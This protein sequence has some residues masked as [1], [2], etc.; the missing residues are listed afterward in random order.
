MLLYENFIQNQLSTTIN[1][2]TAKNAV[3]SI[4]ETFKDGDNQSSF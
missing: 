1:N 3:N 4:F 2:C